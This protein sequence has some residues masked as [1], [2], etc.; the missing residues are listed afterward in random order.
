MQIAKD[1]SRWC[2]MFPRCLE[3][4]MFFAIVFLFFVQWEFSDCKMESRLILGSRLPQMAQIF[5]DGSR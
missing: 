4:I 3:G 1:G 2:Q 5:P